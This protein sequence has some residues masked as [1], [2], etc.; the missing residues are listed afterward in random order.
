MC[1][2]IRFNVPRERLSDSTT[3]EILC[4]I[5]ELVLNAIRHGHAAEVRVAGAIEDDTL[6]FSVADNGC[7][8]DPDHCPGMREGHYGLQ[9]VRERA[10]HLDGEFTI[11][12]NGTSGMKAVV[13]IK[14]P[15][16]T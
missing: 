2:A 16:T 7:G 3:H 9:G 10:A 1:L 8:F 15:H 14:I 5:R 6:R 12:A 4:I 13:S 11:H